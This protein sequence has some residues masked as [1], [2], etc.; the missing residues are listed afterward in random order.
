MWINGNMVVDY[1]RMKW[2]LSFYNMLIENMQHFDREK[3][4]ERVVAFK[5]EISSRD[6]IRTGWWSKL[7]DAICNKLTQMVIHTRLKM[8]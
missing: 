3:D 4:R 1:M 6:F 2:T 8:N 7:V 5:C